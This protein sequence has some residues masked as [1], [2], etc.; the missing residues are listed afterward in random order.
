[1]KL[2]RV[3]FSYL[4]PNKFFFSLEGEYLETF[5][6]A[7]LFRGDTAVLLWGEMLNSETQNATFST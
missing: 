3:N 7:K 2:L 6:T 1:M 5:C 4:A